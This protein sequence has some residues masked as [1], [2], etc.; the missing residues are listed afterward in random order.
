[1]TTS[2]EK[3]AQIEKLKTRNELG[4]GAEAVK[5]VQAMGKLTARERIKL[6]ADPG[7][8]KELNLWAEPTRTGFKIDGKAHPGDGVVIGL[9]QVDGRP[10]CIYAHDFTVL[11]GSQST[12]LAWKTSRAMET[13]LKL[14]IPYVGLVDSGGV[15]IQDAFGVNSHAGMSRNADVYYLPS[16]ASGV[17]PSLSLALG[18]SYAGTA[19]SPFLADV[20][21]M[22]KK[23]YCYMSLA[24]P[25]LLKSVTSKD[26]TREEIGSPQL[27][28]EVTGS[29]DYLGDSEEDVIEKARKLLG[30]LPSNCREKPPLI[31]T[32]D[33][34]TRSDSGLIDLLPQDLQ[35]PYDMHEVIGRLVDNGDYLE[36]KS[37]YAPNL[38]VCFARLGGRSVGIVANNPACRQG[39][40][41][42]ATLEKE[43]RF[44]RYCDAYNVPLVFL[45]DTPGFLSDPKQESA[46]L[47]RH[48]A[49]TSYAICEA[50]VPKFTVHIRKCHG[51]G[52]MA[53][54]TR[55]MGIDVVLAWPTADIQ[56]VDF[57]DTVEAVLSKNLKDADPSEIQKI[58]EEYFDSPRRPGELLQVD[59][60][61]DPKDTRSLLIHFLVAAW[62]KTEIEPEKKSGNIPL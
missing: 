47:L 36:L 7:S 61:I 6:F 8:F 17:V 40:L 1:M 42:I 20:F 22:V 50:T 33:D 62:N 23:D 11:G 59:D 34:K 3:A 53:M 31:D 58:S 26:V 54:G 28:A 57:K 41:D 32:G 45:V 37:L 16:I 18:P 25:E 12:V 2:R 21:F 60:I 9:G 35:E 52:H 39:A 13:A 43:A 30:F 55:L 51:N 27:H 29:C 19:Y 56:Q 24:S 44:I 48:A 49:M 38:I 5:K 15:R 46:G 4:G 14:G 10:V